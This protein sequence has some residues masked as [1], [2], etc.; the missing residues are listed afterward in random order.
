M[1]NL[2][3]FL[4]QSRRETSAWYV[5]P[6]K[7]A[8]KRYYALYHD[9]CQ[10]AIHFYDLVNLPSTLTYLYKCFSDCYFTFQKSNR[11]LSLMGIG[12]VHEQNNAF[13]KGMSRA[14]SVLNKDDE[15]GLARWELCLHELSLIINVY[16]GT[17]G[18]ELNFDLL[19][20]HEDSETFQNQFSVLVSR[21]KTLVLT[22]PSKLNKFTVLNNE[23]AT[24]NDMVY[25]EISK[26]SKLREE[27]RF[28]WTG[29]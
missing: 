28:G 20:C 11:K 15:C 6:F 29:M 4:N 3:F 1:L 23:K 25:D 24:F 12:Q 7:E 26:M 2:L 8:V 27:Q 21:L 19:K 13:I 5:L 16:E 9:V 17:P 22:N 18:V 14:R 10:V